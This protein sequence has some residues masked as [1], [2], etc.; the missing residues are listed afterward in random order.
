MN[1][2]TVIIPTHNRSLFIERAIL[3]VSEQSYPSVELIVVDDGSTDDTRIRVAELAH[4]VRV[5]LCYI[6]Q[7]NQGPAS[8][9]NTG[10][11]AASSD[12]ICFLD[13]DDRF[14]P[15][16]I[17]IQVKALLDSGGLISHTKEI[18]YRRGNLLKQKKKHQPPEGSIFQ[19]CLR[20]CV[21]GMS[22][23]M[24]RRELFELHGWFDE[25]FPCCEDYDYWLRV[26]TNESFHLVNV[27]LTIKDGGREDQLSVIHR[28]GMDRYRIKSIVN[29]LE[30]GCLTTE[31][32]IL[33]VNELVCKCRIYGN[34]CLKHGKADEGHHY[35]QIPERYHI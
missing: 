19:N 4:Q 27:P 7:D 24:V 10:I 29:L 1:P 35:L 22:T 9:R 18:W 34:G 8:A 15:D 26:S 5:P 11:R 16:K 14:L 13:S 31:Q 25:A 21:V 2:A 23:V 3:S 32:Y 12:L 33:A 20:M 17:S 28:M 6:Y 30:S